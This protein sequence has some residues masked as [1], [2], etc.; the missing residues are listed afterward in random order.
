MEGWEGKVLGCLNFQA[1]SI[2]H[3]TRLCV[4]KRI[5]ETFTV[6]LGKEQWVETRIIREH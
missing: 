5:L 6:V 3:S 1:N 4:M 2:G